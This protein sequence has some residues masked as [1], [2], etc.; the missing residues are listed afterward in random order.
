MDWLATG[1]FGLGSKPV[2]PRIADRP[3][4]IDPAEIRG[5]LDKLMAQTLSREPVGQGGAV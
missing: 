1:Y 5:L 4:P 3:T 2:R